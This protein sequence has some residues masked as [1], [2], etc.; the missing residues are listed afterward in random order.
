M[1]KINLTPG[2]RFLRL[3]GDE[4]EWRVEK[5]IETPG[6]P[7][8]VR[9]VNETGK[10][11]YL[12]YAVSVLGDKTRF[13]RLEGSAQTVSTARTEDGIA[14]P[15]SRL[16]GT[17]DDGAQSQTYALPPAASWTRQTV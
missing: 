5:I 12:T 3:G 2:D 13:K 7:D 8:H 6:V 4:S 17:G 11:R 16:P 1:R 14:K 9:L 15:Q 10:R